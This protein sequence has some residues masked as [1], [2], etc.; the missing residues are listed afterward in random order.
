MEG[1]GQTHAATPVDVES[2]DVAMAALPVAI[3]LIIYVQIR[4]SS[5]KAHQK[6]FIRQWECE[7]GFISAA[8]KQP[9]CVFQAKAGVYID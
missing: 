6:S 2:V 4:M 7:E 9:Y 3:V 5:Q 1:V 8:F